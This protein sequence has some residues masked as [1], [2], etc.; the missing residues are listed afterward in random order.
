MNIVNKQTKSINFLVE[1]FKNLWSWF[2]YTDL[3]FEYTKLLYNVLG[4][5]PAQKKSN[6]WS[7]ALL[8]KRA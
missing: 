7:T 4:L 6:T 3:T 8:T 5:M 1:N 2:Q